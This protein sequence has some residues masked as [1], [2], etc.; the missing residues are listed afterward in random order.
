MSVECASFG[1]FLWLGLGVEDAG[2]SLHKDMEPFSLDFSPFSEGLGES[3]FR[4]AVGYAIQG[5][6]S[7]MHLVN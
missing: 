3:I 4:K 1:A 5:L 2:Q 6:G 7:A